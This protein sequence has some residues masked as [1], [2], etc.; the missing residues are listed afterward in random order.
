MNTVTKTKKTVK[1]AKNS[2][3]SLAFATL[4]EVLE[5]ENPGGRGIYPLSSSPPLGIYI[6]YVSPPR[7][8]IHFF[9]LMLIPGGL[10]GFAI[11]LN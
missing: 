10:L 4:A 3:V 8:L 11:R 5:G 2:L 7:E 9:V 6:A 1:F